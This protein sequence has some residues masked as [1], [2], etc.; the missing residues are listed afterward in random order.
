ML[1]SENLSRKT[2]DYSMKKSQAISLKNHPLLY[3]RYH[4]CDRRKEE[5][6]KS[7]LIRKS[8][9]YKHVS[10]LAYC[11]HILAG[12]KSLCTAEKSQGQ[13]LPAHSK[14]P[15]QKKL[16]NDE[17]NRPFPPSLFS[18]KKNQWRK[19]IKE[20]ASSTFNEIILKLL[21]I[22][23]IWKTILHFTETFQIDKQSKLKQNM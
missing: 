21:R 2:Y 19:K 20:G 14:R 1:N 5:W 4:I 13:S 10:P 18:C 23:T 7:K 11:L 3:S 16:W 17:K 12:R 15:R 8:Q 6:K 22:F 9:N